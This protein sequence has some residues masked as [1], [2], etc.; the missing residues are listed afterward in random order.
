MKRLI[1]VPHAVLAGLLALGTIG[2][3]ATSASADTGEQ[4]LAWFRDA[5]FGLFLHWVPPASP[6]QG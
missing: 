1:G 3:P 6:G 4:K 2:L 5:K